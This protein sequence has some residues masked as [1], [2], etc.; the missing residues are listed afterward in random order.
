V[1]R[2]IAAGQS[3]SE[4]AQALVVAVST[5][6]TYHNRILASSA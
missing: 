2:S 5:V 6:K 4:I 1:L 3:N